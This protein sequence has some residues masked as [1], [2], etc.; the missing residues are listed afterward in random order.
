MKRFLSFLVRDIQ[1]CWD[2]RRAVYIMFVRT[3]CP[4]CLYTGHTQNASQSG[5]TSRN[6]VDGIDDAESD[7]EAGEL[8]QPGVEVSSSHE[9]HPPAQ[10]CNAQCDS[11]A[12]AQLAGNMY[13]A[14]LIVCLHSGSLDSTI[15]H[16]NATVL[17]QT[18]IS[19]NIGQDLQ[20]QHG[21]SE[22]QD[23]DVTT[24]IVTTSPRATSNLASSV[25]EDFSGIA[26]LVLLC[27]VDRV[28]IIDDGALTAG[29]SKTAVDD[30]RAEEPL[31]DSAP[32]C[33]D[34][35]VADEGASAAGSESG[36]EARA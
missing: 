12:Q 17:T 10:T 9:Q 20:P 36:L 6:K 16:T 30:G 5:D 26:H 8:L 3:V 25:S 11:N 27:V 7:K 33:R 4:S 23:E 21:R 32:D 13:I 14:L 31:G 2:A 22:D 34:S 1:K 24:D 19:E 29:E 18:S 28:V 15:V 35:Y